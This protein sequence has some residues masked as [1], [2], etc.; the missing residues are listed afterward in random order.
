MII[1]NVEREKNMEEMPMAIWVV[2]NFPRSF[3]NIF[4]L[5]INILNV[6]TWKT[7]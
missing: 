4:P 3:V 6:G 5:Q 7:P 1:P 2:F